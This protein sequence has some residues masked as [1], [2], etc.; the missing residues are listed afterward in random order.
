[1]EVKDEKRIH[2]RRSATGDQTDHVWRWTV[3]V[4]GICARPTTTTIDRHRDALLAARRFTEA[5]RRIVRSD[6]G[7]MVVS[8]IPTRDDERPH[9]PG[10]ELAFELELRGSSPVSAGRLYE[11]LATEAWTIG[12]ISSCSFTFEPHSDNPTILYEERSEPRLP[13]AVERRARVG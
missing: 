3:V 10:E 13:A 9:R 7:R 2:A 8:V 4:H 1:M 6:P 5:A 12:R 11:R